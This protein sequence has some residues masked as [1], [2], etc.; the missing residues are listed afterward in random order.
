MLKNISP[1]SGKKNTSSPLSA[2]LA[3]IQS[4]VTPDSL[5]MVEGHGTGSSGDAFDVALANVKFG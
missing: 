4:A 2:I 1:T 3:R 5:K